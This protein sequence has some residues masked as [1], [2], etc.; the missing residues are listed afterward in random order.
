MAWSEVAVL[1]APSTKEAIYAA[2]S[3]FNPL[4][5]LT[6][7]PL[8]VIADT[9]EALVGGF[10]GIVGIV[11]FALFLLSLRRRFKLE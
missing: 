1:G 5:L 4:N 3:I 6:S 11:A 10:L 9:V 2:Q 8:G 7:K